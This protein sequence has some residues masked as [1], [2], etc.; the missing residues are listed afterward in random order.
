MPQGSPEPL[1]PDVAERLIAF[2]R[3]CKAATRSVTLY[4]DGHPAITGA[5]SRQVESAQRAR[6]KRAD[7]CLKSALAGVK[8]LATDEAR[9]LRVWFDARVQAGV[10]SEG[11]YETGPFTGEVIA[12]ASATPAP[13]TP[14]ESEPA[15]SPPTTA[16][17]ST[18][19][20]AE[21]EADT[22]LR[23]QL[24][25]HQEALL[26]C[27]GGKRVALELTYQDGQLGIE[28]GE[29]LRGSPEQA[30]VRQVLRAL[31]A[32]A[33]AGRVIHVLSGDAR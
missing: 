12:T 6:H 18:P 20:P 9:E 23:G 5:L 13:A 25:A 28:L 11:E 14:V 17:A 30:C 31:T 32:P 2:A 26:A 8:L 33:G 21:A 1:S 22:A 16:A 4:P 19:P 7:A 10:R 29:P 27:M 15:P 24:D 3:A